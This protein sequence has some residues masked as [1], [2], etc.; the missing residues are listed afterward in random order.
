MNKNIFNEISSKIIVT[1]VIIFILSIGI[2][3]VL[4]FKTLISS[5]KEQ[6]AK[7]GE[8]T[9]LTL[10]ENI[11]ED[12]LNNEFEKIQ[13]LFVSA[14]KTNNNIKYISV[15]DSKGKCIASTDVFKINTMLNKTKFDQE[16]L[17]INKMIK[18]DVKNKKNEFEISVPVL[19]IGNKNKT[20]GVIRM[21]ISLSSLARQIGKMMIY[22]LIISLSSLIIGIAIYVF[23]IRRVILKPTDT[24][25]SLISD[26]TDNKDL[27]KTLS[28]KSKDKIGKLA[29][30]F[31]SFIVMLR[32]MIQNIDQSIIRIQ[33]MGDDL[34]ASSEQ[35]SSS[36]EE[37]RA[38]IEGM[39][40]M[41]HEQDDQIN[42]STNLM[43]DIN[44]FGEKVVNQTM[45]QTE[46]IKMS[47]D[48]IKEMIVSIESVAAI[49]DNKMEVVNNLEQI[50][51]DGEK[52]MEGTIEVIEK[53]TDSTNVIM[54][55]LSIINNIAAQTNLL[56]M[57]AAIE[58]AHAG[59][60]G[61]GF[62]VVAIEIRNLAEKTAI[63]SK[64]I[65]KSLKIVIDNIKVSNESS[66]RTD[67]YFKKIITG[68]KEV[69]SGISEIKNSM[70]TLLAR[71]KQIIETLLDIIETGDALKD[72]SNS[73]N[74]KIKTISTLIKTVN[75]ISNTTK[76][77]I[78]EITT[79]INEI[80]ASIQSISNAGS[81][82]SENIK[83]VDELIKRFVV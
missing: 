13:I 26:I 20:L 79:G 35:S 4:L 16:I 75:M 10:R 23:I 65:S 55:M 2:V 51:L 14:K 54:N 15:V 37:I 57:N 27:T 63:N 60:A 56:A 39:K 81:E 6:Y 46:E 66:N 50:A 80:Y 9:I 44:D 74:G 25:I 68:I 77:G 78:D 40:N 18:R 72:S 29:K 70:H 12:F 76:N 64:E 38:N 82:N 11:S 7:S 58:A 32:E 53:I 22:M 34:A 1:F 83:K 36:I 28:I 67:E 69:S 24:V 41:I 8:I 5:S 30:S 59:D 49:T 33:K 3:S 31:N 62:N 43:T 17:S 47:S 71:D 52:E 42:N 19:T 45:K 48:S 73:M 61:Q 21:G